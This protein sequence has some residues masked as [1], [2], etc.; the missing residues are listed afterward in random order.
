MRVKEQAERLPGQ[1][2][3][4]LSGGGPVA[5]LTRLPPGRSTPRTESVR[6]PPDAPEAGFVQEEF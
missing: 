2:R 4:L 6:P 5:E 1:G 3:P